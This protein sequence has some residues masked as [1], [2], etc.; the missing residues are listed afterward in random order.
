V[1]SVTATE[2]GD[3]VIV[4]DSHV[5][6]D[7]TNVSQLEVQWEDES[8]LPCDVILSF[9]ANSITLQGPAQ[10]GAGRAWRVLSPMGVE[11]DDD[12]AVT[13]NVPA[14]GTVL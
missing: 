5:I 6:T 2:S 13:M 11:W 12:P 9:D 10:I 8:W 14:G 4:F 1:V 3:G 7:V